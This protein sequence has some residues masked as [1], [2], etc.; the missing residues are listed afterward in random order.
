M[1][2]LDSPVYF[3]KP[4]LTFT[5]IFD[6]EHLKSPVA[7]PVDRDGVF[8]WELEARFHLSDLTGFCTIKV[9]S[10]SLINPVDT[11]MGSIILPVRSFFPTEKRCKSAVY[12]L[13]PTSNGLPGHR[14]SQGTGLDKSSYRSDLELTMTH[15]IRLQGVDQRLVWPYYLSNRRFA[16][17]SVEDKTKRINT[18]SIPQELLESLNQLKRNIARTEAVLDQLYCSPPA[19]AVRHLRS[20]QSPGL[21][22]ATVLTLLAAAKWLPPY[23]LPFA[24]FWVVLVS[25]FSMDQSH[26]SDDWVVFNEDIKDDPDME[27]SVVQ[28]LAKLIK[29][30]NRAGKAIDV[31]A[32]V[33]EKSTNVLN[34]SDPHVTHI[35]FMFYFAICS[36]MAFSLWLCQV[37]GVSLIG[38]VLAAIVSIPIPQ[39]G[40]L[41]KLA[42]ALFDRIPSH[43]DLAR[44]WMVEQQTIQQ[45]E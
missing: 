35:F 8:V 9:F 18:L 1:L 24:M 14:K 30:F 39:S 22:I 32:C 26:Y 34:G 4:A 10:I 12:R 13:Y 19:R 3:L 42:L 7:F 41:L 40:G 2:C 29:V 44:V 11:F 38:V 33:L 31:T 15:E 16:Y 37:L 20:W 36:A 25:S 27:L 21:T 5:F 28:R 43:D 23:Q 6:R 45:L 17:Q